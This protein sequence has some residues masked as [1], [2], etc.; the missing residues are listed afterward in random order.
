MACFSAGA[1]VYAS[2][3]VS[4][5]VSDTKLVIGETQCGVWNP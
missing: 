2:A 4:A 1:R 5:R 3:R